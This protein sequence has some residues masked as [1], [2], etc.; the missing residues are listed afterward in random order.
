LS[1]EGGRWGCLIIVHREIAS[2][3]VGLQAA[4]VG[5]GERKRSRD[6]SP[7]DDGGRGR[8]DEVKVE[9]RLDGRDVSPK[10]RS[11]VARTNKLNE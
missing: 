5:E 7:V 11:G 8:R 2:T 9:K 6:G 10:E 3:S 4:E 1:G